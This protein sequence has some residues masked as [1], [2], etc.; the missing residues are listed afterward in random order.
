[1]TIAKFFRFFI[2]SYSLF[3]QGLSF[4]AN[5]TA[6]QNQKEP[7]IPK[8]SLNATESQRQELNACRSTK[9]AEV[10]KC[11]SKS[12]RK[13]NCIMNQCVTS[14]DDIKF[15]QQYVNCDNKKSPTEQASCKGDMRALAEEVKSGT[16]DLESSDFKSDGFTEAAMTMAGAVAAHYAIKAGL[17]PSAGCS[18][19]GYI[20]L[21]AAGISIISTIMNH[22]DA[23]KKMQKH[24]RAY[25]NLVKK[26]KED[27]MSMKV[28][29]EV[30]TLM[31]Q[32]LSDMEQIA[33][34]K[35]QKHKMIMGIYGIGMAV[36]AV[37]L[38]TQWI[39]WNC[40]PWAIGYLGAGLALES[41]GLS[42][43]KKMANEYKTRR[44]AVQ[45]ILERFMKSMTNAGVVGELAIN[46]STNPEYK[47]L[48][49]SGNSAFK[50]IDS[51][52]KDINST[53]DSG[54]KICA[55]KD[56]NPDESCACKENDSCF[57]MMSNLS[58]L[59][60]TG[61][62]IA[63]RTDFGAMSKMANALT[64]GN[65]SLVTLNNDAIDAFKSKAL[66]MRNFVS[67]NI[68]DQLKKEGKP[69]LP[70]LEASASELK[71]VLRSL[72]PMDI[73]LA[74]RYDLGNAGINDV[75][76]NSLDTISKSN[77][78]KDVKKLKGL[79]EQ[80]KKSNSKSKATSSGLGLS[81]MDDLDLDLNK[82]QGSQFALNKKASS[83]DSDSS[84]QKGD[85]KPQIIEDTGVSIFRAISNRYNVMR[86]EKRF[87][88]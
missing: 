54:T 72:S 44:E 70:K 37:E 59:G 1:M 40:S 83:S 76:G 30:F 63:K 77:E 32:A 11:E 75:V 80:Y 9:Q 53:K 22:K 62:E 43:A 27:G 57:K 31:I 17:I 36:V 52:E 69:P 81:S 38:A 3:I 46:N 78:D 29:M 67:K 13:Y 19:A 35:A 68:N 7:E 79:Y 85:T 82:N 24:K 2:L 47:A 21:G 42:K 50:G 65:A 18:Q 5:S 73:A 8:L 33:N 14:D 39:T 23:Q 71:K 6:N 34:K 12:S 48:G 60:P 25:E 26:M 45:E 74:S 20:G 56:A 55:D 10:S 64:N 61:N 15:N 41:L 84:E 86:L 49:S 28:Q 4:A 51:D 87:G 58:K 88:N 16:H 66:R